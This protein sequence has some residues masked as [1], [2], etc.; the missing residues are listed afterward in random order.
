MWLSFVKLFFK[1][2]LIICHLKFFRLRVLKMSEVDKE[3]TCYCLNSGMVIFS[4]IFD[5]NFF[6]TNEKFRTHF[7]ANYFTNTKC[8]RECYSFIIQVLYTHEAIICPWNIH[9]C[10]CSAIIHHISISELKYLL[11]SLTLL[12]SFFFSTF[13]CSFPAILIIFL[14]FQSLYSN[15]IR[16]MPATFFHHLYEVPNRVVPILAYSIF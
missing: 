5:L 14:V 12:N 3:V 2:S 4:S 10:P 8:K 11:L 1:L 15:N 13:F 6:Q 9:T 7:L 16:T